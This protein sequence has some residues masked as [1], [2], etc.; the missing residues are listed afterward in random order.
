M[1]LLEMKTFMSELHDSLNVIFD[2]IGTREYKTVLS[3]E[4]NIIKPQSIDYGILE[5]AKNIYTIPADFNWSD[6][7][8]WKS[9]Y[10][11]MKKDKNNNVISGNAISID[12]N[13]SLVLSP[14]NMTAIIGLENIAVININNTTLVMPIN[15]AQKVKEIISMLKQKNKKDF[16]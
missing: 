13:N 2:A 7:G 12:S 8:S 10:N 15:K 6:L 16:L 14:D 5:K 1:I 11:Y 4:W 9:Y 3:S